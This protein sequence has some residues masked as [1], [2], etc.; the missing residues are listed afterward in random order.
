MNR[1]VQSFTDLLAWQTAFELAKEVH[2]LIEKLPY[3]EKYIT[4]K[5]LRRSVKS[6]LANIAEGFSRHTYPDKAAKYTI[7]R[8]ENSEVKAHLLIA[9][10]IGLLREADIQKALELSDKTGRLLSGLITASRKRC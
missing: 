3:E 4:G 5:Q 10:G 2:R 9:A 1:M 7:S 6:I 8:G